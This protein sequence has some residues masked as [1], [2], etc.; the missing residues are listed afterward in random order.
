MKKVVRIS[1][2]LIALVALSMSSFAQTEY[3]KETRKANESFDAN[4]YFFAIDLY[5]KA[6]SKVKNREERAEIVYRLGECYR[7]IA[8]AKNAGAQYKRA[9]KMKYKDPIVMLR[10]A[11]ALKAQGEYEDAIVEYQNYKQKVPGDRRAEVGIESCKKAKEWLDNPSRY[12]VTNMK[13]LN[14]KQNEFGAAYGGKMNSSDVMYFTSDRE[15]ANGNWEDGWTGLS[16]TDIFETH[17]ERKKGRRG[18]GKKK[19]GNEPAK[20]STAVPIDVLINTKHHEGPVCFDSRRK[21]MYFTRCMKEKNTKLGCSIYMTKKK[22][23]SW[24]DPEAVVLVEDSSTVGHPSLSPDDKVLYF[25]SDMPGSKGGKDIWMATFDRREKKWGNLKN[26]GSRI[27]TDGDDMFPFAH[28]D[29][30]LYFASNGHAGMG[31]MDIYRVKVLGQ[32][33]FGEVENM[34][35][36]INSNSDDFSIV[37]EKGAAKKGFLTSNRKGSRGGDDLYSVYLTPLI[38]A[39]QGVVTDSK[40]GKQV[41][42]VTVR[43]DGSDGTSIVANTDKSGFYTFE[44]NQLSENTFYKLNFEK[45]K[46]L[47]NT[48]DVT[49]VGVPMSAFELTDDGYLH[50][51]TL[52]KKLDPIIDPIVLPNV[53]FDLGKWDVK[54]EA[55]IALDTVVAILNNNPTIVI[56]LRSHTDFRDDAVKNDTLSQRRARSCVNY[57]IEKGIVKDRLVAVGRGEREPFVIPK[58]Y[59]G[60]GKDAF[61]VGTVLSERYIK[62]LATNDE[63]EIAHQINRRT[64]FK[65]LRD[66]YVPKEQPKTGDTPKTGKEKPGKTITEGEI[67]VAKKGDSFGKVAKKYKISVRDLKLLNGG[68]RGVRIFEG[69]ELKVTKGGDYTEYDSTHYQVRRGDSYGKIAKKLKMKTKDL[70]DLNPD[71]KQKDFKPG[72]MLIIQ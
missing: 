11:D 41:S 44:S 17:Q 31:G 6:Y 50:T 57:L 36:P 35:A 7:L 8:D 45:K 55:K 68:L 72:M 13:E 26:L 10:Y 19:K 70:K 4:E 25:A 9:I 59:L 34:K 69:L 61:K 30:Y 20:W 24:S 27:N 33:Q 32:G 22:G 67:Y 63:R 16:F 53:L 12:I 39:L 51:L 48:G 60:F 40:T 1:L 23:Q 37:F 47:T 64:D 21:T 18:R 42:G 49:T 58:N 29:G 52:N 65:V 15:G 14:S 71:I 62:G 66:D 54:P 28:D 38:F 2:T 3:S 46:Y 43:L 56:E 5:K